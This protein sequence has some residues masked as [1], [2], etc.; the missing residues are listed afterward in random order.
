MKIPSR[1]ESSQKPLTS[2]A[3]RSSWLKKPQE[4]YPELVKIFYENINY[5]DGIINSKVKIPPVTLSLEDFSRDCNLPSIDQD[6]DLIFLEGN[7]FNFDTFDRTSI[8]DPSSGIPSSFTAWLILPDYTLIHYTMNHLF[9][10]RKS[11]SRNLDYRLIH[12][13]MNDG[14]FPRKSNYSTIQK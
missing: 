2:P 8:I 6:Y 12:H 3:W 7:E 4:R 14:L 1:T 11:N 13:T 9:F 5:K 10:S